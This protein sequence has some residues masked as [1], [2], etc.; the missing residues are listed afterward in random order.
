MRRAPLSRIA[1]IAL[2]LAAACGK[3]RN[4]RANV[5]LVTLDT[6]RADRLGC[7]GNARIE[8]PNLDRLAREGVRFENAFTAVPSTLPSHASILTG[9]YPALHGVHDNGVYVLT[10]GATTLAERFHAAG[11]RTAAF[12][13]AFVLDARFG[14]AQGFDVYDDEMEEPLIEADP[15]R[16]AKLEALPPAER[17]RLVQQA[18][19]YQRRAGSV[20]ERAMRWLDAERDE[21]FFLWVHCF[22]A[23]MD[24]A[25]PPPWNER[26]DPDYA[27]ELDG[28]AKSWFLAAERHGW[29]TREALPERDREH[30]IALYDGELSY[31]D[32]CLGRLFDAL[33]A[34]GRWDDTAIV[35]VA[36]HGEG[37]GEH[38]MYW[39]H[40]G[41]IFDE[42]MH[43]PLLVKLPG[44]RAAGRVVSSLARTIDVAPT[45]LDLAHLAPLAGAQGSSLVPI[46][47]D[48]PGAHA[49]EE[50]LL[51]ALRGHQASPSEISW[52]GLRTVRQKLCLLCDRE[53][54]VRQT[55]VFDLEKDPRELHSAP[56]EDPKLVELWKRRVLDGYEEMRR[57]SDASSFRGMDAATN[58]ALD[59]LGYTGER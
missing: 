39:E 44:G 59:A 47:L 29:G 14:L 9:T 26:Y 19:P 22:D 21:P 37:F 2:F 4:E 31:M 48:E 46:A 11:Y 43:V 25:P 49:P 35:V 13:S 57:R 6:T 41:Q 50:A 38:G 20:T 45:A 7:Y 40:N 3:G 34:S 23:H 15:E 54:A 28:R 52:L 17:A 55:F 5:L 53:G 1:P 51:E 16:I 10:E 32:A 8:T 36:D 42:T 18:S 58:A 24:Y 12:V 56:D 33:R 30:M 27:G